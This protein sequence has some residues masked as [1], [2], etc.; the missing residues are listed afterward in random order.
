MS[1]LQGKSPSE[2]Y[3]DDAWAVKLARREYATLD[4]RWRSR[5][6]F[7]SNRIHKGSAVLDIG[8]GDGVLGSMLTSEHACSVVGVDV[9]SYA[10]ALASERGVKGQRVDIDTEALPFPD[11]TFDVAI[12]SCVLEHI[13]RPEHVIQ[14]AWR[15]LKTGGIFYVSLPNPMTWKIRL[16]FIFGRFHPD[17]LHSLP[18]EGIHYR[19]WPVRDGLEHMLSEL[20]V[21][22]VVDEKSIELKNPRLGSK[23]KRALKK[24]AIR[25]TPALFGE[26]VHFALRKEQA[27]KL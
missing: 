21:Q 19:F 25:V 16:A 15:V 14:E 18:G 26:Y 1:T 10:I 6:E 23:V 27:V 22:F 24:R 7:V 20:E 11:E 8:C 5:W 3:Y 4:R 12:A 2:A 9:S 13:G 17:F